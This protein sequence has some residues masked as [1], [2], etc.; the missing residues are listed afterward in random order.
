MTARSLLTG[1]GCTVGVTHT[2]DG[3]LF[4]KNRDLPGR[5]LSGKTGGFRAT[6][7]QMALQGLDFQSNELQGVSIGVSR[8][9]ICVANTHVAT[10]PDPS[11]DLLTEHLLNAVQIQSDVERVIEDFLTEARVQG[12]RILVAGTEWASLVEVFQG[13]FATQP[14]GTPF[15][16]TNTFSLLP[17]RPERSAIREESSRVRLATAERALPTVE[18]LT[19]L[20][21]LLRSHDPAMGD[22]SI[23]NHR[24]DG[25]GTE[26]SHIIQL[27][28]SRVSW[29][30]LQGSPCEAE[31][32]C[33]QLF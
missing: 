16:M 15:C 32:A 1:D 9:G 31:Y 22:L 2:V 24:A 4:F 19:Q 11:Y 17:H 27:Q 12:G 13:D 14:V 23:C 8:H 30:W 28:D 20:Q 29:W 3:T 18:N 5:F 6:Y 25:G 21:A 7:E 10:T 26:S 33:R